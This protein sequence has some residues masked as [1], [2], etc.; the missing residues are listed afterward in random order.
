MSR[1]RKGARITMVEAMRKP[2]AKTTTAAPAS[3]RQRHAPVVHGQK[4][5]FKPQVLALLG[6][7]SYST[8]WQWM[9]DGW[10]PLPLELGPPNGRSSTIAW[11]A[12][13]VLG[14]IANRPRRQ[15]GQ[16]QHEF[17]GREKAVA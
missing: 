3:K 17:R 10:F 11:D 4:L 1:V 9:K 12:N 6:L 14:W 13:E 15:I 8:L 7:G 16:Q 5:L 2:K